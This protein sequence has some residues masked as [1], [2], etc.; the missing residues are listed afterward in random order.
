MLLMTKAGRRQGSS[1]SHQKGSVA[2]RRL[3]TAVATV[4]L[5]AGGALAAAPAGSAAPSDA[6]GPASVREPNCNYISDSARPIVRPNDRGNKVKQVQCLINHYSK[7]SEYLDV[8]GQYGQATYRGVGYVQRCNGTA[9]GVDH[10]VGDS[11]WYRL[12]HPKSQCAL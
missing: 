4:A 7:F 9:G 3:A 6:S 2:H 1:V 11:T 12:Y 8:D 5:M 10:V